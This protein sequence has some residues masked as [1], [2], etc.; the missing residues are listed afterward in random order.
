[1]RSVNLGSLPKYIL[2]QGSIISSIRYIHKC[3]PSATSQGPEKWQNVFVYIYFYLFRKTS[4]NGCLLGYKQETRC[5]VSDWENLCFDTLLYQVK[6]THWTVASRICI[7]VIRVRETDILL[8][9]WLAVAICVIISS[10]IWTSCLQAELFIQRDL[11]MSHSSKTKT[12]V[13]SG[14]VFLKLSFVTWQKL[15]INLT[16]IS[17]C[18]YTDVIIQLLAP[19]CQVFVPTDSFDVAAVYAFSTAKIDVDLTHV[20]I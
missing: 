8:L 12:C 16:Q 10:G 13:V 7:T 4:N 1:M 15:F 17:L 5:G 2:F 14:L 18:T 6:S 11:I 19:V 20:G 9:R 3:L